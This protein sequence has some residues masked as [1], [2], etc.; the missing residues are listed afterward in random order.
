MGTGDPDLY[1]AFFVAVLEP[2]GRRFRADRRRLASQ[3]LVRQGSTEFRKRVFIDSAD[4]DLTM[5]LNRGGW[6][7]D[8]A[9]TATRLA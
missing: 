3:C 1:K 7:F 2:H 5:L 4:I 8:E 9:N 6:V